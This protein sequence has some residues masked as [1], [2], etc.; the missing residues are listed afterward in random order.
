[1]AFGGDFFK[2]FGFVIRVIRLIVECFGDD[3]DRKKVV[4]AKVRSASD[5]ADEAC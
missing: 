5:N 4:E 1:M 2:I 3:E